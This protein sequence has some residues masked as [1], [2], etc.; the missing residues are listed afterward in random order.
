MWFIERRKKKKK[1]KKK[2]KEVTQYSQGKGK[3][4]FDLNI[5]NGQLSYPIIHVKHGGRFW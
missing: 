4:R 3:E 2:K 5:T 1:K